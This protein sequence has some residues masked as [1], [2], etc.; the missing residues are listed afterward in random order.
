MDLAGL[1]EEEVT[2]LQEE[3]LDSEAVHHPPAGEAEDPCEGV[4]E[5]KARLLQVGEGVEEDRRRR[6]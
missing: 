1:V 3:V 4:I 2:A 6:V 5:G